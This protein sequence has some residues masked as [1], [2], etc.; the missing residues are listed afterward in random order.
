MEMG[1]VDQSADE[2]SICSSSLSTHSQHMRAALND[3]SKLVERLHELLHLKSTDP[4]CAQ[5]KGQLSLNMEHRKHVQQLFH[6]A[7]LS[8][9]NIGQ[10]R[11]LGLRRLHETSELDV[12][13]V[14]NNGWHRDGDKSSIPLTS[15]DFKREYCLRNVPCIIRGFDELEFKDISLKWRKSDTTSTDA[16]LGNKSRINTAWFERCVGEDTMVPVR[17]DGKNELDEDGRAE[18][19]ETI[20]MSLKDWIQQSNEGGEEVSR[21]YLKDWH[22]VQLLQSRKADDEDVS[23]ALP[24]YKTPEY[25]E[26]DLLNNFLAKYSDGGDYKFVYWGPS[27]SITR[28]HSDVLHSFSWSYNVTG[29]KKWTFYIPNTN[30]ESGSSDENAD[31]SFDV[32]QNKGETIFVSSQIKHEVVNLVETLSIN[33]NWITSAN[34]DNTWQCICSE[35]N[36]IEREIKEWEVI[37]E[38]DFEARENMLRGCIGLDVTTFFFMILVEVSELFVQV[39]SDIDEKFEIDNQIMHDH[40]VSICN[41]VKVLGEVSTSEE[42]KTAQRLQAVLGSTSKAN[43]AGSLAAFVLSLIDSL[44]KQRSS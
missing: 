32:I 43:Q 14:D 21:E 16:T 22:L 41:L 34:I 24:L 35:I 4:S 42:A 31:R 3:C 5:A 1:T 38:D 29:S 37:P 18:E 15:S 39:F 11:E 12:L 19:C 23:R 6:S 25:F 7:W 8:S 30:S 44:N 36:A 33:H 28:L 40:A 10:E 26:R 20:M 2:E 27:G 17:I 9:D 13:H